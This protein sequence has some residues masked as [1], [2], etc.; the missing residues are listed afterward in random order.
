MVNCDYS[1][2]LFHFEILKLNHRKGY[3]IETKKEI[4]EL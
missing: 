1:A 2:F 4:K 3:A